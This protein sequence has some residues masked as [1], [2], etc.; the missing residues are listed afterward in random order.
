MILSFDKCLREIYRKILTLK[1][2]NKN[3]NNNSNN[4]LKENSSQE[5]NTLIYNSQ[6]ELLKIEETIRQSRIKR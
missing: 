2:K 3:S 5:L 6:E 1:Q 4:N